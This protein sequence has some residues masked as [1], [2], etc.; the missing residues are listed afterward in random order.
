MVSK[1][2]YYNAIYKIEAKKPIGTKH[3]LFCLEF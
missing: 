3:A 2:V 1:L